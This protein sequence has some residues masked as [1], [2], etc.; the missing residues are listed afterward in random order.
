MMIV[1]DVHMTI[2]TVVTI[3]SHVCMMTIT[4]D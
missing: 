4:W 2:V 1:T 3:V